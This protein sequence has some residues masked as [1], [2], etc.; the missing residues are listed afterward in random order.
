MRFLTILVGAAITQWLLTWW[1]LALVGLIAGRYLA[2]GVRSAWWQG[3]GA[4]AALWGG[5]A[6]YIHIANGYLL[7]DRLAPVFNLP[8]G[9]LLVGVSALLGALLGGLSAAAGAYSR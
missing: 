7:G 3:A 6:A 9:W 4:G 1:M 5:A 8:D 2:G